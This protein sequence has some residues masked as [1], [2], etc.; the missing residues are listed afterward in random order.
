MNQSALPLAA[1]NPPE[2]AKALQIAEQAYETAV[3]VDI[4]STQM[5][6]MAGV[7]LQGIKA[8]A[9]QIDELRLSLTRPLDES[10]RRIMD[11]FRQPLARLDEAESLI[12]KGMVEFQQAERARQEHA[13]REAEDLARREREVLERQRQE[14]EAA[15]RRVREEAAAAQRVADDAAAAARK[16]GDEETARKAEAANRIA[17]AQAEAAA[18]EAAA[19][20]E[21]AAAEIEIADIAPVAMPVV[22]APKAIGISTRQN[23]KAEVIDLQALVTAAAESAKRGDTTLLGYLQADTK[24]LGAV[25][26]ALKQQARIPGVRIYAEEGLAVRAA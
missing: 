16:A 26:K 3:A 13:R 2:A 1:A 23:W 15:A 18:A 24:A 19:A 14:A 7:E 21:H 8:R 5:F 22:D 12:R 9:K 4:D 20:A 17:Q 6:Q 10:K 25:A 11:L